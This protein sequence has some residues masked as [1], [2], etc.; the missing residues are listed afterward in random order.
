M[1]PRLTLPALP[2]V[3][4][5]DYTALAIAQVRRLPSHLR[6]MLEAAASLDDVIQ[7][8][9]T[10]AV[11]SY[12]LAEPLKETSLR[13]QRAIHH[14]LAELGWRRDR[15]AGM[16]YT[17]RHEAMERRTNFNLPAWR[18][19]PWLWHVTVETG[20]RRK[21]YRSEVDSDLISNLARLI[22]AALREGA[23]SIEVGELQIE[24]ITIVHKNASWTISWKH[25]LAVFCYLEWNGEITLTVRLNAAAPFDA[26]TWGMVADAERCIAWAILNVVGVA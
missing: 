9:A 19:G 6:R 11:E 22:I 5:R 17:R 18:L 21:S 16:R 26:A 14:C 25:E 1:K 8:A 2:G 7:A 24:D 20:D 10:A 12:Q 4:V 15:R 3:H 23:D 13:A